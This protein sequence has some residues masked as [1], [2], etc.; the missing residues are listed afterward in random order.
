MSNV[1][2]LDL[3]KSPVEGAV[4][5]PLSLIQSGYVPPQLKSDLELIMHAAM[6]WEVHCEAHKTAE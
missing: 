6:A 1:V 2:K 5:R 3:P 4:K